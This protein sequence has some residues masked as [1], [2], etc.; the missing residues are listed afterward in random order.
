MD[1]L[2]RGFL[3]REELEVTKLPRWDHNRFDPVADSLHNAELG[4]ELVDAILERRG[5]LDFSEGIRKWGRI[6]RNGKGTRVLDYCVYTSF[7]RKGWMV[8][9]QYWT[10]GALRRWRSWANITCITGL[11]FSLPGVGKALRGAASQGTHYGQCGHLSF[12]SRLGRGDDARCLDSLYGLKD[13]FLQANAICASRLN[14]RNS[15]VFW[16]SELDIDY[17]STFLKRKRDGNTIRIRVGPLDRALR[18]GPERGV[19]GF[20]VRDPQGHR[21]I[22]AGFQ[23]NPTGIFP[24]CPLP[25]VRPSAP[26]HPDRKGK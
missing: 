11:I 3:S 8:P 9:N 6:V 18:K 24:P 12:S 5:I 13:R 19:P 7:G 23:L 25:A 10:P 1:C 4:T 17:V 20:L 2:D 26:S 22:A 21:R 15:G 16:E 14:S